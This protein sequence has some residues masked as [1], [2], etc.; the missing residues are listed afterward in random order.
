MTTSQSLLDAVM[1]GDDGALNLFKKAADAAQLAVSRKDEDRFKITTLLNDEHSPAAKVYDFLNVGLGPNWWEWEIETIDRMILVKYGTALDDVNR[2]KVLAI[3]HACRSDG[4]FADW[5]EFNQAAL[6]FA[7]CI[8]DFEALRSPTPGMIIGAVKTLNH[9]RP[10]REKFYSED[11]QKYICIVLVNEGVYSPPPSLEAIILEVM[12]SF[13]SK[14]MVEKW[15]AI[16]TRY[17]ELIKGDDKIDDDEITVQAKRLVK[18]EG[19]S[20]TYFGA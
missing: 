18:A 1:R 4:P 7:G 20:L 11:V 6:S 10:D 19:S 17:I 3:R 13:V 2:D 8:A 5:F 15:P 16:K 14:E 12:K 9:I